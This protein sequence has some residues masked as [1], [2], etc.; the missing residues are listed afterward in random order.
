MNPLTVKKNKLLKKYGT[1]L[2]VKNIATAFSDLFQY[3]DFW[4]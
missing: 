3:F 4:F 2:M 1:E